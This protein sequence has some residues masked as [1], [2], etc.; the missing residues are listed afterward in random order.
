MYYYAIIMS[1]E[2]KS[3]Q[4]LVTSVNKTIYDIFLQ[5]Q[6]KMLLILF[7]IFMR[8]TVKQFFC[9]ECIPLKKLKHF[10]IFWDYIKD[11]KLRLI[12]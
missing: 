10:K 8:T 4:D 11:D 2:R 9:W 1:L 12:L 5:Q 7:L 6:F 3:D